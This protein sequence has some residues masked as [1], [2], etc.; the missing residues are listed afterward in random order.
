MRK[1]IGSLL[2]LLLILPAIAQKTPLT[3]TRPVAGVARPKLVIG[4]VIDQMRWDYLY[5][6][7]GLFKATGGF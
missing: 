7:N 2:A 4:I 5:R 1:L 6:Y 3:T